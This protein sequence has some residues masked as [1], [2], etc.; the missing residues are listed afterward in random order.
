MNKGLRNLLDEREIMILES[1]IAGDADLYLDHQ[2]LFSKLYEYYG[3]E[4]PVGVAKART[5]D[6]D[7]W[8]LMRVER[9][10]RDTAF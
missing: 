7:A 6:P 9:D 1:C 3:D 4:M 8:I 2:D 5:G 10:L